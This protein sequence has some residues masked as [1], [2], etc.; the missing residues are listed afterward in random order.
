VAVGHDNRIKHF[1]FVVPAKT[2]IFLR[3]IAAHDWAQEAND[4]SIDRSRFCDREHELPLGKGASTRAI[5]MT[6]SDT[7]LRV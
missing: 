2:W 4:P 5:A 3:L 6:T 7:P 1:S